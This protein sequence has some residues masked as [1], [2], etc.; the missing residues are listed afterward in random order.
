[1]LR[2]KGRETGRDRS[3]LVRKLREEIDAVGP[4]EA[5]PSFDTPTRQRGK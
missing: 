2:E 1:L 4:G 3:A 5:M